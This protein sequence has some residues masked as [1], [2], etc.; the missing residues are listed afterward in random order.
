MHYSSLLKPNAKREGSGTGSGS[1]PLT[2]GS[3]NGRPKKHADPADPDPDPQ[4]CSKQGF[5][6]SLG[7]A[8]RSSL[9]FTFYVKPLHI[10][11]LFSLLTEMQRK[12]TRKRKPRFLRFL[13][14][15]L[16]NSASH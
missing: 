12:R 8:G 6:V 13:E 15:G 14:T 4:H 2:N 11:S 10:L 16:E 5:L 7:F 3:G 9:Y 1:V